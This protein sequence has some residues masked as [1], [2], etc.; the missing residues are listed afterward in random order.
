M[1]LARGDWRALREIATEAEQLVAASAGTAFC[2][3]VT[4]T[5]A[6]A[7][8]AHALEGRPAEARAL[9]SRAEAP[10]QAEPLERESVLLRAYGA[11]GARRRGA[12]PPASL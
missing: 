3:A 9:L 11:V 12:A 6:F 1:L 8:V 5:R 7:A 2:Y 10:L 4:T